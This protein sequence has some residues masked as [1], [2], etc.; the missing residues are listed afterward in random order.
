MCPAGSNEEDMQRP[1]FSLEGRVAVV[2][3][4]ARVTGMLIRWINV[5]Q[6]PMAIGAK[7]LGA[8]P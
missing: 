7:P 5:R 4:G 8:L 2:T 1:N 3:G 6:S